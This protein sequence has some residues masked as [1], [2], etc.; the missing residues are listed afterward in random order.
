MKCTARS[1]KETLLSISQEMG[2][3]PEEYA[4]DPRKDFTRRRAL[5]LP[6]L[7][8]LILTMDEKSAWKGLLGYFQ[9]KID[10]PLA[11]AFVQQRK[12]LL[13]SAF[14]E[15]FHR[16][17]GTLAARKTYRGHRLLS[18]DGTSLKSSSYPADADAFRPGTER[19]PGRNLYHINALF[20]LENGI[21]TDI[22]V[23]K[24]HTKSEDAALCEMAE[25]S[26]NSEP[27]I[28]PAG[29]GYEAYNNFEHLERKG[30]KY[31]IRLKDRNRTYA[32]GITLPNHSESD[33]P[34]RITLGWLTRR[35][36]EQRGIP[37]PEPYYRLQN[38]IPF[39]LLEPGSAGFYLFSAR[40]VRPKLKD[41]STGPSSRTWTRLNSLLRHCEAFMPDAGILKPL[42][43]S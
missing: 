10:T 18:V 7:M 25:C 38:H 14:S 28:L 36:M 34:V 33:L 8:V 31:L 4:K 43:G 17:T 13:P 12:K 21:Y 9:N 16:F 2:E 41:G 39:D 22:L 27:V 35:Q 1:L 15:L 40:I 20:D 6:A 32:Y 29:R 26:T 42:S 37:V 5:T 24:E 11:S 30:W 19:Q 3:H 23:Q